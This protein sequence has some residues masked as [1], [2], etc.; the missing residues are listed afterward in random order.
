MTNQVTKIIFFIEAPFGVR[1]YNRYG[2]EILQKNGF[3]VEVW[4]FI[5]FLHP[6]VHQKVTVPDPINF[7][8]YRQFLRKQD[9]LEAIAELSPSCFVMCLVAYQYG[10][11]PIYRAL[12]KVKLQRGV[13][14]TNTPPHVS[15]PGE[16]LRSV[17]GRIMQYS[18]AQ[19]LNAVFSRIPFQYTGI[20]PASV[21]LAGGARSIQRRHRY[22]MDG[23]TTILWT[24]TRDYDLY[25]SEREKPVQEDANIGVFLD[26]YLPFHPDYVR[27]GLPPPSG[28][29]SYFPALRRLFDVLER[30]LQIR[31][32]IAAHP[33]ARYGEHPDY[34]GGRPIVRGKTLELIR[35]SRFAIAHESTVLNFAVLFEK[36]LLF[37]T[38]DEIERDFTEAC[39]IHAMAA[40]LNKTAI[41]ADGPL[42]LDW[43]KELT[44]DREAYARYR[45]AHIKK[46]SSPEKP[47]WQILADYLKASET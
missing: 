31:I 8:G 41:N 44:I 3:D 16:K 47:T 6:D 46:R 39:F 22:P 7:A 37:I 26:E 4:D 42:H 10:S 32:V 14:L 2:I 36:P 1:N 35:K 5:P 17:F 20:R 13:V 43:E 38:T 25:L 45:E 28:P 19:L 40:W 15:S 33:L 27:T 18:P 9:A 23:E 29:D 24:H 34:F 30:E 12:S 21:L 11:W